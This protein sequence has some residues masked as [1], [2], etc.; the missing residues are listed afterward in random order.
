MDLIQRAQQLANSAGG[1]W[2]PAADAAALARE[3]GLAVEQLLLD[4]IPLAR[5]F[6][7]PSQ[8]GYEVGAVAQG[9]SGAVYFGANFEILGCPLSQTVHAEQSAVLNAAVHGEVGLARLAVSAAPCGYCRQFLFEL[10]TAGRLQILL[11]DRPSTKLTDYIPGAFGPADLDVV[12]G[13]LGPQRHNLAWMSLPA[14]NSHAAKAAFEAAAGAYAPY[15]KAFAGA[16]VTTYSGKT[17]AGPYLENAAFNPSLSPLQAA[18][19]AA[20]MCRASP[21]DVAEVALVQVADSKI[22]HAAAAQLVL[23]KAAPSVTIQT[24]QVQ[25]V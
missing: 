17:Y 10:A 22:D 25:I 8:S 5:T 11:A 16:A 9:D 24:Y 6:A 21:K 7:M 2:L 1:G 13:L 15:T 14:P 4:L 18:L 23:E 12:G 3:A 20:R 19:V